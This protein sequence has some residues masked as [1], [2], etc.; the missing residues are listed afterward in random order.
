MP[1]WLR[2]CCYGL[3]AL[4]GLA[5]LVVGAWA[6][7]LHA[8][9]GKVLRR[10][11]LAGRPVGNLAEPQL[12]RVVADVAAKVPGSPVEVVAPE[13]GFTVDAG[14]LG[15]VVA[16]GA[17]TRAVLDI[18]RT[19]GLR[20]QLTAWLRSFV[21]DRK[22][23]VQVSV[24]HRAVFHTVDENDPGPR[25]PPTEPTVAYDRGELHAVEGKDG[26]GIDARD[27]I[28]NLPTAAID[29]TTIRVQVDRGT[30]EPRFSDDDADRLAKELQAKVA[31]PMPVSAAGTKATV[32]VATQRSW[33]RSRVDDDAIVP[34]ID[35]DSALTDLRRLLA[36]AGE[37]AIE[38]RFTVDGGAVQIVPG[39]NGTRCCGA[40]A[41][42]LVEGAMFDDDTTPPNELPLTEREPD[43]TVAEAEQLGV[44]E[45]MGTFTTK[46][47]A[48][49]PRV[50][51]IHRIADLLRGQLIHPGKTFSVNDTIGRRTVEKGFVLAPV[52]ANGEHDEDIGGGISQM[53]TTL[54]N[55]AFF[56][57]LDF[58]EYQS[59]SLY[60]SRYPYGREATMGFPHPDLQIKNTSPYGVLLWPTYDATSLTV[61]LYATKYADVVQSGQSE[62]P[63]GACKRVT[64]ERTR[65]FL[66]DGHVAVDKVFATYRPAEGV[67]C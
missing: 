30:V 29:G 62:G 44:K 53:A 23:P 58:G 56:A 21:T 10:V 66:S 6:L 3:V 49:Q 37:P 59:H 28:A 36:G 1:R 5:I 63:R 27:V 60:I 11:T 26:L 7:D 45:V 43:L 50:L 51:N 33:I 38:T 24:D 35:D 55:A 54:F 4:L 2:R 17:T 20:S 12:R 42:E 18:G 47:P 39:R 48:G 25:T 16:E 8:H 52:I 57:G 32:P 34:T 67:K 22:A 14:T 31:K 64:T 46:H 65:T 13:G 41:V 61:T 19:G 40:S 9:D 15:V